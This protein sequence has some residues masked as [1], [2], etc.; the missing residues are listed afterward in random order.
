MVQAS[1]EEGQCPILSFRFVNVAL[2]SYKVLHMMFTSL[3][4]FCE[5]FL[6]CVWWGLLFEYCS[7]YDT[8]YIEAVYISDWIY[9]ISLKKSVR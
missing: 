3:I 1:R 8:V 7:W 2:V 6:Y 5:S 9:D 4:P